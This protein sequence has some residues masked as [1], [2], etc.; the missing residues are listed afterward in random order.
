MQCD[1][2][3]KT[4]FYSP[5]HDWCPSPPFLRRAFLFDMEIWQNVDLNDLNGEIWKD[6]VDYEGL[7][8]VSNLGRVKSLGR[9]IQGK[10]RYVKTRILKSTKVK[11]L[12]VHL[13]K[14][15]KS[16]CHLTHILIC[17]S[18]IPN[19][20][21]KPQVNHIYGIK[22]DNRIENLEWA[23]NSENG[24]HSYKYLNRNR[25]DGKKN[26]RSI[27]ILCITNGQIYDSMGLAAKSLNIDVANIGRVC[28]NITTHHKNFKFK[29]LEEY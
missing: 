20:N 5:K 3:K 14:N 1:G 17:K 9:Q 29:F 13:S 12:S 21:N 11:Y 16:K 4:F 19:I 8:Q 23:T 10:N 6:M 24:L 2:C 25:M 7:Y 22:D 26:K 18:F 28:R 15:K 27:K